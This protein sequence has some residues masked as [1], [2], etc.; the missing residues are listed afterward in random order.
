MTG[1]FCKKWYKLFFAQ[2]KVSVLAASM[3]YTMLSAIVENKVQL[4][5]DA[6]S[7]EQSYT[8]KVREVEVIYLISSPAVG[9]ISC[10]WLSDEC[11]S[12]VLPVLD[13]PRKAIGIA[14]SI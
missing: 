10:C 4:D 14:K 11:M 12:A 2:W 7:P 1:C 8:S 9:K 5:R 6:P 13:R 3:T